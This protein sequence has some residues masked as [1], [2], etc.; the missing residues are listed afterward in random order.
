M[1]AQKYNCFLRCRAIVMLGGV[2]MC[3]AAGAVDLNIYGV[4]HASYDSID[5]GPSTSD[6]LHSNS[7]RLGLKGDEDLGDGLSVYF[8]YESG[9]DLTGNGFGDGNG[10]NGTGGQIFTRARD[11]FLGLKSDQYGSIQFGRVGGL[12]Q[13]LYDYNLFADQVGDLGNIWGGDG[14]PGRLNNTIEYLSPTFNGFSADVTYAPS[15]GMSNQNSVIFKANYASGALKLGGAYAKFGNSMAGTPDYKAYALTGSYDFGQFN[16]GGGY[17]RETDIGGTPGADRDKFTVGGAVKVGVNGTLKAQ[18]AWAG[19]LSGTPNSAAH[20]MVVGYDYNL[21]K[22]AMVYLA[23]ART[24]NQRNTAYSA[25]DYGHG[26]EG[27]PA[28][29][30]GMSPSVVSVGLVY[31]FDVGLLK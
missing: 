15:Q 23:Y 26:N 13:W 19:K 9:V 10:G 7:S 18:Y 22:S 30:D 25:Y 29:L 21:G 6:Y 8:Q 14:L 3:S 28:I 27:T 16:L 20:Q 17:Q 4:G 5:S 2:M 12:N 24:S 31:K 1:S 11:S